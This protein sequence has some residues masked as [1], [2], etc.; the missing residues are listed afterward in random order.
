MVYEGYLRLHLLPRL[1]AVEMGKLAPQAI[2]VARKARH[3]SGDAGQL[4][5]PL[6]GGYRR[7]V[8]ELERRLFG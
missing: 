3:T 2:E 4:R 5:P 1:G 8:E 7:G 6:P